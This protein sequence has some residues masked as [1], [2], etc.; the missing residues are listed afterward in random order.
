MQRNVSV[1]R[2]LW[3]L[4]YGSSVVWRPQANIQ[5]KKVIKVRIFRMFWRSCILCTGKILRARQAQGFCQ[6]QRLSPTDFYRCSRRV[7]RNRW[8][9]CTLDLENKNDCACMGLLGRRGISKNSISYF[10]WSYALITNPNRNFTS[11]TVL[12][13]KSTSSS[14]STWSPATLLFEQRFG[15]GCPSLSQ[16]KSLPAMQ[17][18]TY[19]RFFAFLSGNLTPPFFRLQYIL[20]VFK[21]QSF[22]TSLSLSIALIAWRLFFTFLVQFF[23][24][25]SMWEHGKTNKPPKNKHGTSQAKRKM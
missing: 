8:S 17:W 16:V 2:W 15:L 12:T 9:S 6:E 5:N 20:N 3:H 18:H 14:K 23:F 25:K 11:V 19:K 10:P 7:I 1:W 24:E 21:F 13:W 4:Q 22:V